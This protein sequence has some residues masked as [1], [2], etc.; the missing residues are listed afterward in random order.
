LLAALQ[1]NARFA[2]TIVGQDETEFVRRLRVEYARLFVMNV[3]PY[4]SAYVDPEMMLNTTTTQGVVDAYGAADYMPD[5]ARPVGAPDHIGVELDLMRAL[6]ERE[7][8]DL[9]AGDLPAA[10]SDRTRQR[11]FLTE[12]L[13]SW[14][15]VFALS[16]VRDARLPLY[17]EIGGFTAE[18]LLADLDLLAADGP[19]PVTEAPSPPAE[20]ASITAETE[21]RAIAHGLATPARAGFHLSREELFRLA[22]QLELPLAP[23]ERWLMIEQLFQSAARYGQLRTLLTGL[24]ETAERMS[25]TYTEW[26]RCFPGA[27]LAVEPWEQRARATLTALRE[28]HAVA[29]RAASPSGSG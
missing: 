2:A 25:A 29:D 26:R 12:H 21:L 11:A 3:Y 10:K 23:V 1:T 14:G 17:R 16:V 8:H 22:G 18:F 4:E 19:T 27:A 13:A 7:A 9:A 15:P 20:I 6:A 5:L 24:V 28:M